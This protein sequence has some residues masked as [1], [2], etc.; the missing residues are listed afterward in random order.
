MAGVGN[1]Q[2]RWVLRCHTNNCLAAAA[3]A[4]TAAR[5]CRGAERTRGPLIS[6]QCC[7]GWGWARPL[8][9]GRRPPPAT[10]TAAAVKRG[11]LKGSSNGPLRGAAPASSVLIAVGASLLG[12]SSVCMA[13]PRLAAGTRIGTASFDIVNTTS[14][15]DTSGVD[16]SQPAQIVYT[17]SKRGCLRICWVG[18]S[19]INGQCLAHRSPLAPLLVQHRRSAR[20]PPARPAPPPLLRPPA[21][22]VT[23][24]RCRRPR[25]SEHAPRPRTSL[26]CPPHGHL[27]LPNPGSCSCLP[28]ALCALTLP[29]FQVPSIFRPRRDGSALCPNRHQGQ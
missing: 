22:A 14:A 25:A 26:I 18:P 5:S 13:S 16:Q 3:A 21:V 10:G 20:R 1:Q 15:T 29:S 17:K 24:C 27:S 28:P 4:G 2:G 6:G 23:A 9:N 19:N 11:H 8:A 7:W 12:G